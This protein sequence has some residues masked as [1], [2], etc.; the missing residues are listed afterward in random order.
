MIILL[1]F[2]I[3]ILLLWVILRTKVP[4]IRFREI[5]LFQFTIT[6]SFYFLFVVYFLRDETY[7]EVFVDSSANQLI[8]EYKTMWLNLLTLSSI[9]GSVFQA[10]SYSYMSNT[11]N[12]ILFI[13]LL[14]VSLILILFK[15]YLAGFL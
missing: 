12:L 1:Y 13:A 6:L 10:I 9:F 4:A 5:G 7:N 3:L 2:T 14:F 11:I 15:F 8:I